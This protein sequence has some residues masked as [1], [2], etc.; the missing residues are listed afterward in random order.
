MP[1]SYIVA[2]LVGLL[3]SCSGALPTE[4]ERARIVGGADQAA[5]V[6][7]IT[8]GHDPV[9]LLRE[10]DRFES[11]RIGFAGQPSRLVEAWLQILDSDAAA[12]HFSALLRTAR[13]SEGKMYALTGLVA[14]NRAA[15]DSAVAT[16]GWA[17]ESV[18]VV[19][20]C[21]GNSMPSD[22]LVAEIAAG[23]WDKSFRSRDLPQPPN[24]R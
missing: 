4:P 17:R 16:N 23:V 8:P 11:A 19:I 2:A 14:V 9:V 5:T 6:A 13:T 12:N 10:A 1:R 21:I 7:N 24:D 22:S 3:A 20:G 15:F 18:L